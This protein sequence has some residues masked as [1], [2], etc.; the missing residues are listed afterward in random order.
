MRNAAEACDKSPAPAF[1][2]FLR[3]SV[4]IQGYLRDTKTPPPQG[5]PQGPGTVLQGYLA[6]IRNGPYKKQGVF[7]G[8]S[9]LIIRKAKA[10]FLAFLDEKDLEDGRCPMGFS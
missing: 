2:T 3:G 7:G 10:R 9:F 5:P 1:L 4:Y 8:V 6:H